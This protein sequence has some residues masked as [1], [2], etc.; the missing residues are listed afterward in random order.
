MLEYIR[1]QRLPTEVLDIF[2][3]AG[4]PFYDGCLIV[5]VH[6]HRSS[7]SA[8]P[9]PRSRLTAS[10]TSTSFSAHPQPTQEAPPRPAEVYRIVLGPS[11]D[12]LW[13]DMMKLPGAADWT[14]DEAVEFEGKILA[15]TSAP[16]CLDPSMKV[17]RVANEM[18]CKTTLERPQPSRKRKGRGAEDEEKKQEEREKLMRIGDE[19]YGRAFAP[20]YVQRVLFLRCLCARLTFYHYT[21]FLVRHSWSLGENNV[22]IPR[23]LKP[24]DHS[25][26]LADQARVKHNRANFRPM[27]ESEWRQRQRRRQR[28]QLKVLRRRPCWVETAVR[29]S[30]LGQ[31]TTRVRRP[32]TKDL[33]PRTGM[34]RTTPRR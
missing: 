14:V 29:K 16:L 9:T 27:I 18:L 34:E 19:S 1:E 32:P 20:T 10:T 3:A 21:D 28:Q 17:S 26:R 33:R 7:A 4:V 2:D 31:N 23:L 25:R 24:K 11:P 15:L 13:N 12:T 22:I 30:V 6:D 5:E 8:L